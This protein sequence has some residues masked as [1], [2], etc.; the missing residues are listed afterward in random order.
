MTRYAKLLEDGTLEIFTSP[1][2]AGENSYIYNPSAEK[3]LEFGYK[4]YT[5]TP[6]DY[7]KVFTNDISKRYV[8]SEDSITAVWDYVHNIEKDKEYRL[9]RLK[10]SFQNTR[11]TAH[12]EC[13]LGFVIDANETAYINVMGCINTMSEEEKTLFR[14]YDNTFHEVTKAELETIKKTIE[15]NAKNLYALKWQLEA[16][17][18]AAETE[19]ELAEC[20]WEY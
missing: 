16:R 9:E 2:K 20:V 11:D 13:E 8:E 10:D 12:C 15:L 19:E 3:L 18:N 1:L 14:A 6:I 17:I 5:E 4:P 7:Q